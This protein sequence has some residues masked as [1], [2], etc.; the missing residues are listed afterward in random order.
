MFLI[1]SAPANSVLTP[2]VILMKDNTPT[3]VEEFVT[4]HY[5]E[6]WFTSTTPSLSGKDNRLNHRIRTIRTSLGITN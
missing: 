1:D 4:T 3:E 5:S 6:E 2:I